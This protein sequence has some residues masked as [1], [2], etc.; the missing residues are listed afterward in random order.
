[1]PQASFRGCPV[2]SWAALYCCC[3][4][5]R[6]PPLLVAVLLRRWRSCRGS[7]WGVGGVGGDLPVLSVSIAVGDV[8]SCGTGNQIFLNLRVLTGLRPPSVTLSLSCRIT[9]GSVAANISALPLSHLPHLSVPLCGC[10]GVWY[11]VLL[12]VLVSI[13]SQ[14]QFCC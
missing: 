14:P 13:R 10:C 5:V 8:V 3:V 1:M 4:G 6:V 7:R 12:C 2:L 11:S 9:C